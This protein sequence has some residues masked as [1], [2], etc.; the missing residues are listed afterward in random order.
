MDFTLRQLK[1][2]RAVVVSGSITKACRRINLSQ[3]SI[4][5]QLAKLEETLGVR[6]INRERVGMISLTPAGE[7]WYRSTL[8]LIDRLDV[9][10]NEHNHAFR[11][12][13][14]VLRFGVTPVIRGPFL[15]AVAG[16]SRSNSTFSR[17]EVVYDLN[18]PR[19]VEQLRSHQIDM[20]VIAEECLITEKSSYSISQLWT[21]DFLWA[22]PAHLTDDELRIALSNAD[23]K[24]INP[25]LSHFIEPDA[26]MASSEATSAWYRANLPTAVPT[27]RAPTFA[28]AA[29]FVAAGL[30]TAN[31][32]R[33]LLPN[34]SEYVLKNIR[35]FKIEGRERVGVLAMRKHL[36]S[37]P[38][39][40]SVFEQTA[41]FCRDI[42][43]PNMDQIEVFSISELLR[44]AKIYA[45][46]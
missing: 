32:V 33:S 10:T 34:L 4:S 35:L 9:I 27:V 43:V 45:V 44:P 25:L 37:H 24:G 39:Y 38:Y 5:Q 3:P 14:L 42:Y 40:R 31:I 8:E 23:P 17:F 46:P 12:S 41:T 13:N 1:I 2:F 36:Q 22:V 30:G 16:I 19:L 6:L 29:E 20:A 28:A 21:E 7:Y 26:G 15:S 18:S 11:S